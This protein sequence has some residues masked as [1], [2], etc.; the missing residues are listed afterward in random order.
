MDENYDKKS[1][2]LISQKKDYLDTLK[3]ER[4]L[5]PNPKE[6]G[7]FRFCGKCYKCLNKEN[8]RYEFY[9]ILRDSKKICNDIKN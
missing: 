5:F 1:N 6:T 7:L 2:L 9:Y 3:S 8:I 4:E